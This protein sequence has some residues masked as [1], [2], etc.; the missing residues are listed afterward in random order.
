MQSRK[1]RLAP[2]PARLNLPTKF[3]SARVEHDEHVGL[4][5]PTA[6]Q[7]FRDEQRRRHSQYDGGTR[8]AELEEISYGSGVIPHCGPGRY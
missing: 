8:L 1:W 7:H 3:R 4:F 5:T 2:S 6:G